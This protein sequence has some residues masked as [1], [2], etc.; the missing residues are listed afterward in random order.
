[1]ARKKGFWMPV[2]RC[3][4]FKAPVW[5]SNWNAWM[6]PFSSEAKAEMKTSGSSDRA[7]AELMSRLVMR[8]G[9]RFRIDLKLSRGCRAGV[10]KHV[11]FRFQQPPARGGGDIE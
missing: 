5:V 9:M 3:S 10:V 2:V 7:A 1:M 6:A 4:G 11:A 8:M